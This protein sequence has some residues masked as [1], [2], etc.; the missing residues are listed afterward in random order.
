MTIWIILLNLCTF[1][2]IKMLGPCALMGD[3]GLPHRPEP[4]DLEVGALR[5][6]LQNVVDKSA[7]FHVTISLCVHRLFDPVSLSQTRSIP[8]SVTGRIQS[9]QAHVCTGPTASDAGI[10][11]LLRRNRSR[12]RNNRNAVQGR[13]QGLHGTRQYA[14]S[15][16]VRPGV[17]LE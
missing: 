17:N 6:G 16:Q 13:R 7:L 12:C 1:I 9:V 4:V 8:R 10:L 14:I 5:L 2:F 15:L 11:R 3:P